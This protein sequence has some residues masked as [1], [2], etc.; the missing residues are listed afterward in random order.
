MNATLPTIENTLVVTVGTVTVWYSYRTPVAFQVGG[1]PQ[2]V[3]DNSWGAASG[4]HLNFIDGGGK[5]AK[6]ARVSD[7]DFRAA[8]RDQVEAALSALA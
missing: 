5:D 4:K 2:V 8:W 1:S 6:K 3:R 7:D